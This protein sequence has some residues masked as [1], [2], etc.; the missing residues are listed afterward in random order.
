MENII[1]I[2]MPGSGKST[3]GRAL[4]EQLGYTFI[5]ADDLIVL[6]DG[7]TLPEIL[8]SDGVE[9][10][11]AVESRVGETLECENTVIATG[12][13]VVYGA[14]AMKWLHEIGTVIYIRIPYRHSVLTIRFCHNTGAYVRLLLLICS[15][16]LL[17]SLAFPPLSIIIL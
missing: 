10:L 1:L 3:V 12:G 4:A 11:L 9:G 17:S 15:H 7:R 5:D 2:G 13:S 14:R 8:R 16:H 6:A